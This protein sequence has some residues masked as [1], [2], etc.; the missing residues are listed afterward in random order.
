MVKN[1]TIKTIT[2]LVKVLMLQKGVNTP[3]DKEVLILP[4]QEQTSNL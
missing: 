4:F 2:S 3:L 1:F